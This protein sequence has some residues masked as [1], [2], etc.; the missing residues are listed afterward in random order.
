M[1]PRRVTARSPI[2]CI[3]LHERAAEEV[4]EQT[5]PAQ[6]ER[7]AHS[8]DAVNETFLNRVQVGV[9]GGLGKGYGAADCRQD[10]GQED[11]DSQGANAGTGSLLLP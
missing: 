8:L 3:S 2:R 7:L 5:D 11:S 10:Q 4:S 9:G 1:S 6:F